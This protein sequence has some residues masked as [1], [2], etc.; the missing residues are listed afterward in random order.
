M[1]NSEI[2]LGSENEKTESI[3]LFFSFVYH[4]PGY[5]FRHKRDLHLD[6]FEYIVKECRRKASKYKTY[7]SFIEMMV[8][9]KEVLDNEQ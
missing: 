2:R 3:K 5:L 7:A 6:P 1:I 9:T 8:V 4:I